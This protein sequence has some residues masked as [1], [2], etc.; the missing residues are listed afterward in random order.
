MRRIAL[1]GHKMHL[2]LGC[3]FYPQYL[4]VVKIALLH[5]AFF[6][7]DLPTQYRGQSVINAALDLC[8]HAVGIDRHAAVNS[9]YNA[10]H[11]Q[12]TVLI[13]GYSGYL[14]NVS[15]SENTTGDSPAVIL[16]QCFA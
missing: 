15:S 9:S 5:R 2:N 13:D 3:V 6:D 11:A 12:R 4:I 1:G 8:P 10:V 16:G 14:R 7:A